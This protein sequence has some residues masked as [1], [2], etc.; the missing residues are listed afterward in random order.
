MRDVTA[1]IRSLGEEPGDERARRRPEHPPHVPSWGGPAHACRR[2]LR[3]AAGRRHGRRRVHGG[4]RADAAEPH[5]DLPGR[6]QRRLCAGRQRRAPVHRRRGRGRPERESAAQRHRR[7]ELC[8]RHGVDGEQHR[9]RPPRGGER[10]QCDTLRSGRREH[11]ESTAVVGRQSRPAER[12][13][14]QCRQRLRLW[15]LRGGGGSFG[16][17]EHADAAAQGRIE[18]RAVGRD[19]EL[20][21]RDDRGDREQQLELLQREP[22]RHL[23][24]PGRDGRLRWDGSDRLGG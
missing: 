10:Q 11:R 21:R 20:L 12:P 9:R 22:R 23:D 5:G 3:G 14:R 18:L 8:Q 13:Q 15:R 1:R 24:L 4:I 19:G 16:L 2:R 17:G 7:R 6:R